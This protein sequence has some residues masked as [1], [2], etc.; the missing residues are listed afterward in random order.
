MEPGTSA[1]IAIGSTRLEYH[2]LVPVMQ[3]I[4]TGLVAF[5]LAGQLKKAYISESTPTGIL[6]TRLK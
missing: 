4:H 1:V 2:A 6:I 5:S 3:I